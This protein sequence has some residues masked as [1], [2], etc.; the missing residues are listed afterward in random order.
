MVS[1]RGL[2]DVY[3]RQLWALVEALAGGPFQHIQIETNG[4]MGWATPRSRSGVV[5]SQ[6]LRTSVVD[7]VV[8]PKASLSP[9]YAGLSSSEDIER[10][11]DPRLLLR[12]TLKYVLTH[13]EVSWDDGLPT[14]VLGRSSAPSRPLFGPAS[15]VY[16]QPADLKDEELNKLNLEACV[17]S[18]KT[19]GYRLS[20]QVHKIAGLA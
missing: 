16:I 13:G 1:S 10:S 3:K 2:G 6:M 8:S 20:L 14:N 5:T 7:I 12:I 18:C 15:S 9:W 19:F 11:R 4:T 17:R